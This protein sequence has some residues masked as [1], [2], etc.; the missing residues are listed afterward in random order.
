MSY[1]LYISDAPL[2]FG[3]YSTEPSN[4]AYL[5]IGLPVDMTTSY[6]PGTRFGPQHIRIA[7]QAIEF[8]TFNNIDMDD[9]PGSDL[10]D[11]AV[12]NNIRSYIERVKSVVAGLLKEYDKPLLALGGEHTVTLGIVRGLM[13]A[14]KGEICVASFDA[15]FDYRDRYLDSEITHATVMR[16][17][18]ELIGSENI[19]VV[20][21]RAFSIREELIPAREHS[22]GY[23]TSLEVERYGSQSVLRRIKKWVENTTCETVHISID[24]DV[25]DPAYAPGVGNPEPLGITPRQ[26]IDIATGL[27]RFLS[28]NERKVLTL[29]IVEVNPLRDCNDITSI[30][31]AKIGI[32]LLSQIIGKTSRREE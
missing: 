9:Y 18:G 26:F 30:L 31:A 19:L 24:M 21:V 7:S 25:I 2:K 3:S 1:K 22:L 20:G 23:I 12:T 10:G 14:K 16:R 11:V 17:I 6:M 4:A 8:N 15:H 13:T 27:L 5:V 32:E 28:M 29:D